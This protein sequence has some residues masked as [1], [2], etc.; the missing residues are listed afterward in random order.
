[1][2]DMQPAPQASATIQAP[3][4]SQ[5]VQIQNPAPV[6]NHVQPADEEM[7]VD[8]SRGTK[9]TSKAALESDKKKK[10]ANVEGGLL[11]LAAASVASP[12]TA[13][14]SNTVKGNLDINQAEIASNGPNGIEYLL[15]EFES[16]LDKIIAD[17]PPLHTTDP[18]RIIA[19]V[20]STAVE[21]TLSTNKVAAC[22]SSTGT[23]MTVTKR[24]KTVK[25]AKPVV[26]RK[27]DLKKWHPTPPS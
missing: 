24:D 27:K 16:S 20:A 23:K 13:A 3:R 10:V 11:L 19:G 25:V 1:M 5:T 14:C 18:T 8:A 17:S 21:E 26:L 2:V 4:A 22:T 6:S 12:P 9:R 15:H 7:E